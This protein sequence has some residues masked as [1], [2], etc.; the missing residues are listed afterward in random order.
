MQTESD[1]LYE[2]RLYNWDDDSMVFAVDLESI[3]AG[4]EIWINVA[5]QSA[6]L[7]LRGFTITKQETREIVYTGDYVTDEC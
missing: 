6:R 3:D 4:R 1:I 7:F 5:G 2:L